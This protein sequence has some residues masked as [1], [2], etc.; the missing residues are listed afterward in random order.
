MALKSTLA[1]KGRLFLTAAAV[2]AGC[3]FLSGVFVFSDTIRASFDTLFT[4]AY[5]KTNAYVRS[6]NVIEGDF[7][8]D[9]RD[10]LSDTVISQITGQPGVRE[11]DGYVRGSA[12]MTTSSG[13]QLGLDGPPKS[14]GS[15]SGSGASPWTLASGA[16]PKGGKEVVIDRRS[17][18]QGS[19]NLGD[20]VSVTTAQGVRQFTVV[21]IATFAGADTAGASS[22]ALF[23]LPTAEEFVLGRPGMVDAVVVVGDG[24]KTDTELAASLSSALASAKVEVLTKAQITN[25]TQTAVERGLSF[26][27]V[28]LTIFAAISLFVGSFIIYNVFSISAAQRQRENALLRAIGASRGQITRMLFAEALLVG[29][30]GGVV[31]FGAGVLL[32]SGITKLLK[33]IGFG[34]SQTSLTVH[35]QAFAIT[36]V[37]GVLVTMLCALAPALRAGRVPPLAAMR[38]VAVDRSAV[39]RGRLITGIV[40]LVVAGVCIGLGVS[41]SATWLGPGVAALFAALVVLGPLVARPLAMALTKPLRA[42]RGVTGEIAARNAATSPKRTALTAAALGIGLA[43]L[44]GVAT[45]G[46]SINSSISDVVG[47]AFTGDFS[48]T[49]SSGG[50]PSEGGLPVTLASE[51][52][53]VPEVDDAVGLGFNLINLIEKGK[54]ARKAVLII[55]PVHGK[56]I[57]ALPFVAGGWTE[58][59]GSSVLVSKTKADRDGVQLGSTIT[60]SFRDGTTRPLSVAGIFDSKAF[61]NLIVSPELFAGSGVTLQDS[62]VL[63]KTKAGV[64]PK[65]AEKALKAVTVNYPTAKLQSRSQY[66]AAQTEQV[67]GFLNFIYGLLGMSIFIAVLGIVI[68]LLLAVYERRRELGLV[69]A[70]GMTRPQVRSSIRWE[71]FVTALLGVMMGTFLGISL[72]WVVVQALKDQGLSVFSISITSI[73]VSCLLALVLAVAAAWYPASKAAKSD[74]LQA[75]ATT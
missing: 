61:G 22:W 21:G 57:V 75:I 43:L 59:N 56:N 71:A 37:V 29:V 19:V 7:G 51:L 40:L 13:K 46:S 72:G 62:Q 25:E 50:G 47:K 73:V 58:L 74:I 42:I 24:S 49:T 67:N 6:A 15:F 35:P 16:A 63:V 14:G 23:D 38:D 31:G 9:S 10:Q 39:S 41:S 34:P 53:N 68:T 26:F 1:R 66:I 5:A 28:F 65:V 2:I 33:A 69:R 52:N 3:A 17:A 45:L 11:A 64:D 44:I 18:K 70:I 36:L 27:T 4:N 54:P 60:A 48:V 20:Q 32:A 55:D 8:Q 30:I 12:V